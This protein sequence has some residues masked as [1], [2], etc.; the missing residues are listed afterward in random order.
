MERFYQRGDQRI[1]TLA[2]SYRFG[3]DKP[4]P[5]RRRSSGAE[6]EKRRAGGSWPLC[7][8]PRASSAR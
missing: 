3:S 2:F 4:A 1:V 8:V 5:A 7:G 6:D